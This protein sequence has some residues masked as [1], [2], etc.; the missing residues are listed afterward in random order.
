[1]KIKFIVSV[2]ICFVANDLISQVLLPTYKTAFEKQHQFNS[3]VIKKR[4]IKK[5][6]FEIV[7]KKDFETVVDKNL[8]ETYEFDTNGSLLRYYYT[9]IVKSIERNIPL[10]TQKGRK[11]QISFRTYIDYIYDTIS[12]TYIYKNNLLAL[13]RYHDGLN[14]YESRYFQYDDKANMIKE[15]RFKE[16][17]NST[18]KQLFILG[19]QVLL[20]TDSMQFFNYSQ[21]QTKCVYFNSEKRPYKENFIYKDSLGNIIK[22]YENYV[23]ASWIVQEQKFSYTGNRLIS[24]EYFG[25]ANTNF[26]RKVEFEYDALN[27]LFTE[28]QFKNDVLIKEISYVS[29]KNNGLLNS[30]V[31]RDP[32]NKS[33][34]I[35][36]LKYDFGG[37]SINKD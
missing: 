11:K 23:A 34:R 16:T 28:K 37:L 7:D 10:V 19:N 14:Y 6:T 32:I 15:M 8:I 30:F 3:E 29:D 13:K 36:K 35:V 27:E 9:T 2:L 20:S 21:K 26:K 12:T 25:N 1:L 22:I 17:N 31:E 4:G 33:M 18:D 5:I 24:A